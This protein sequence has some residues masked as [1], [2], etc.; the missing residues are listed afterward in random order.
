ML[1]LMRLGRLTA[2]TEFEEKAARLSQVF[3]RTIRQAPSA[4]TFFLM[5]VDFGLGPSHE[6]VIVGDAQADDTQRLL[7]ALRGTFL[8]NKVVAVRPVEHVPSALLYLIPYIEP[9]VSVD[10]KSATVY[11]CRNYICNLPTTNPDVMLG[12]LTLQE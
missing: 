6:V 7:Q 12:A 9:Y 11:V 10:G 2:R 4:Y 3:S 5:G 1:N 8:P